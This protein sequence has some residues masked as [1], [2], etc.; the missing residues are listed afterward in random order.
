MTTVTQSKSEPLGMLP[1]DRSCDFEDLGN[2]NRSEYPV[3]QS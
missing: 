3:G 1:E 2:L